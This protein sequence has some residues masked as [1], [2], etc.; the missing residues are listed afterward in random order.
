MRRV[1]IGSSGIATTS[2]GLG[3]SRL[4]YMRSR[5][6]RRLIEA[7]LAQG[8][9]HFDT[10]PAYGDGLAEQCVGQVLRRARRD[11]VIATKAG[12][13][14]DP[15]VVRY[16]VP[17]WP[18]RAARR[19]FP[20]QAASIRPP[21]T[22][23]G[24]TASLE[25]SLRR[26]GTDYVDL[27]LL[28]EPEPARLVAADDLQRALQD[29]RNAGKVRAFGL[30]GSWRGVAA[31]RAALPQD[32]WV[33]QTAEADWQPPEAPDIT[34]GVLA[35]GP[36]SFGQAG[37]DSQLAIGRLRAARARRPDGVLLVAT[38]RPGRIAELVEAGA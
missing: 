38:T 33:V 23:A 11:V 12:I 26:L 28:H 17:L 14:P 27:L 36:Q 6:R 8:V 24:V 9:R 10:A 31:S 18:A 35:Q 3:T 30:A 7:A 1:S 20:R 15:L 19:I 32:A 4:H 22:A 29:L 2:L 37:I 13:T 25:A 16:S 21:L 34:Y 5:E